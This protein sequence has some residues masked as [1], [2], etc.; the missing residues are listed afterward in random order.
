MLKNYFTIGWRSI[1]RTKGYSFINICGLAIGMAVALLIGLWVFDELNYDRSFK[2]Y[3]R[4]GQVYHHM[5]FGEE[6]LTL[7]DVPAPIGEA[8]KSNFAEF[9]EVAMASWPREHIVAYNETKLSKS[10]LFVEPQFV[11]MFSI[12]IA[13]GTSALNDVHSVM[14]SK[15]LAGSL[16]GDSPVG[17]MIKFDNRDLLTVTGVF[18]DFPANSSFADIKMLLPMAYY[19]SASEANRKTQN[20]WES[21]TFQCFVLLKNEGLFDQVEPKIKHVLYDKASND[22]KAVKPEGIIFLMKK[23]HLYSEFK[24]G[25]NKGGQIKFV[26]MFGIIGVF[27]LLLACINFTNLSTARSEKRSKEV[28]VRKVMG[29]ARNQLV[30]QFLSESLLMVTIGFLLALVMAAVSLPWF[31]V[32]AD[33]KMTMP[34]TDLKFVLV[35]LTF[36]VV[37][38]FLAGSYPA[39]YLSSFNPVRVLKGAFKASRF[40]ALPRKIMVIFQF[41]T[42]IVLIISTMIVFRQIQHAKDRPVGFDREGILHIAIRTEDLAKANY[43]SLRHELL[44]SGAVENMAISDFPITG[45]MSADA[46][47]TW[48]GKDPALRPLVAM[49]SCSHDFPKT[50]GFQFVEGRDFS[51][52][53]S[54]DSAAVIINE[55]AAKLISEKNIIG[56]KL[57]FFGKEREIIGVIKDQVRWTPF[58]KQSPHLYYVSYTSVGYLTIRLNPQ[59]RPHDA[60]EKI[61]SVIKKFDA[62]A[63]FEY[64]F[65]DDDYA[66][67]FSG[68]ERIGKLATIFSI[69]TIFISCM[70]IFGLAAFAASQRTK[71]IGIRKVLGASVFN[72]WKMLSSDFVRLVLAAI[73][74]GAPLA[75][76]LATQW[77]EQYE[78]RV[79]ISWVT[80]VATGL[81][82]LAITLLTV[83][84]QALKAAWMNP[85]KSLRTE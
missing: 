25:I 55:L 82:V 2:N 8:L 62:G 22:G 57:S 42:S 61:E 7:N 71:E 59:A 36:I 44:S 78:Y 38:G 10:G 66:R 56:K 83:S 84:H 50:N 47:L 45:A 70:G 67:Q 53:F 75:Y 60:L 72:L 21:Y 68:E 76:Y 24:D 41:T 54:S 17:K 43:N 31:N 35:S 65:L 77:L 81:L 74:L 30:A 40:A 73:L 79:E 14:V 58:A 32:L 48:E 9:E 34:W 15:T 23:W 16:F 5:T 20:S 13:Q 26:W 28:G 52:E 51:R 12:Q 49:N 18:E 69:L 64:K 80:F 11:S 19:F 37:T 3:D 63:P 29:S 6:T 85:T 46:S 27:V 4:L 39:L 33:K 1:I